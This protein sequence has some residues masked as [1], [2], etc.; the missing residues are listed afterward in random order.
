MC[1]WN[2]LNSTI[3]RVWTCPGYKPTLQGH[4]SQIKKAVKL[5]GEA[6][7]PVIIAGRGVIISS[8]YEELKYLAETAQFR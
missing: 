4:P 1:K 5:I 6:K 7:K 2:R 8:A 3:Q